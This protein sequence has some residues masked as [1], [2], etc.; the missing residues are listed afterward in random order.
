MSDLNRTTCAPRSIFSRTYLLLSILCMPLP[1]DNFAAGRGLTIN[2]LLL[3]KL[4]CRN[5]KQRVHKKIVKLLS[6]SL[7]TAK[8]DLF[9]FVHCILKLTPCGKNRKTHGWWFLS[10]FQQLQ[11]STPF[12]IYIKNVLWNYHRQMINFVLKN[13]DGCR[14]LIL[15]WSSSKYY[16]MCFCVMEFRSRVYYCIAFGFRYYIVMRR[17]G[18]KEA[19]TPI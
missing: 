13:D 12:Q 6:L 4:I 5:E 18:E 9:Q 7:Y 1:L 17:L 19:D 10:F 14:I 3:F 16:Y 11:T 2:Y 15:I 8:L